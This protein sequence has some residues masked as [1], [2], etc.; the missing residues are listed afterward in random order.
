MSECSQDVDI[1]P[2]SRRQRVSEIAAIGAGLLSFFV[3]VPEASPKAL[4][5]TARVVL[6]ID[7]PTASPVYNYFESDAILS[8]LGR[9]MCAVDIPST[10]PESHTPPLSLGG[11]QVSEN[12]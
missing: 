9:S 2:R 7:S 10:A 6:N 11:R 1:Q 8:E 4:Y 5:G 12:C 3:L